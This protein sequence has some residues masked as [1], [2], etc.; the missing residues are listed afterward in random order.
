MKRSEVNLSELAR[1]ITARLDEET[2]HQPVELIIH[3]NMHDSAD[4][5]LLEIVLTNLLSNAYKFSGK[6]PTARIE[7]GKTMYEGSPTY[8]VRDNG[9]G[10]DMEYAKN[11]FGAFQ[12][13]HRQSEFPGTGIGLATVQ[14]IIFRHGGMVWADAHKNQGA[15]FYFTLGGSE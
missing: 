10:F 9:A 6:Q 5:N 14:R 7:F 15:T 11:L 4:P 13:M 3:P 8:F 12:R 1:T 2:G